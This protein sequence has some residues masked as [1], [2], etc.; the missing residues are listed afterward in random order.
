MRLLNDLHSSN[1]DEQGLEKEKTMIRNIA[2][3]RSDKKEVK[4]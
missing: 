2:I 3:N 1:R 4:K